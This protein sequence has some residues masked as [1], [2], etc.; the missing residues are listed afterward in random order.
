MPTRPEKKSPTPQQR[1]AEA[2]VA[3]RAELG[4]TV[5]DAADRAKI[6]RSTWFGLESGRRTSVNLRTMAAIDIALDWS[7]GTAA[8]ILK[9]DG[10]AALLAGQ[11]RALLTYARPPQPP[12]RAKLDELIDVLGDDDRHLLLTIARRL[13][14]Q[15]PASDVEQRIASLEALLWEQLAAADQ[16]RQASPTRSATEPR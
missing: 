11:Q 16:T 5:A 10:D 12:S 6:A 9:A 7:K 14:R 8:S 15:S 1:L 2:I 3:R 4:L 13:A